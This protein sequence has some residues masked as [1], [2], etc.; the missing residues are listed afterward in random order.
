[1]SP[2]CKVIRVKPWAPSQGDFVEINATDFNDSIH[3]LYVEPAT[4]EPVAPPV[5]S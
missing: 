2:D 5:V 4:V 1:M 3:E